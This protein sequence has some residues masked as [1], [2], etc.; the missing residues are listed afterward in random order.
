[1]KEEAMEPKAPLTNWVRQHKVTWEIGP[2]QEMVDHHATV[3]GFELRLF[4]RHGPHAR[5]MAGCPECVDLHGKLRTIAVAAFP[6][7]QRPTQYEVEPFDASFHLRP[8][9]HWEPEVQLT[10][11]ARVSQYVRD[12][13][14]DV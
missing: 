3:V 11:P 5:V 12:E 8:E 13:P 14:H 6:T 1:V 4:G 9:S 2:W 7:E 10:V